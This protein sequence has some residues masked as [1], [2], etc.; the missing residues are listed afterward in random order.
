MNLPLPL[1]SFYSEDLCTNAKDK[2]VIVDTLLPW[3]YPALP[4]ELA[5]QLLTSSAYGT[6]LVRPSSNPQATFTVCVRITD[7]V[8]NLRVYNTVVGFYLETPHDTSSRQYFA[9]IVDLVR[10][11]SLRPHVTRS[12]NS[13]GE[14]EMVSFQL[15]EPLALES[16]TSRASAAYR[17]V[18]MINPW[19]KTGAND[20][21]TIR[22]RTLSLKFEEKCKIWER[23]KV[24]FANIFR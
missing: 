21:S 4:R 12:T 10:Y 19:R 3:L 6:F 16:T 2:S 23:L 22:M 17:S 1:V 7:A 5:D 18:E 14:A 13:S 11:Y 24:F 20:A 8:L 15:I 9:S